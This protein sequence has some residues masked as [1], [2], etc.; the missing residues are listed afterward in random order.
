MKFNILYEHI[1]LEGL[2]LKIRH[3]H[4][5]ESVVY[6]MSGETMQCSISHNNI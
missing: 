3:A 2:I 6:K 4:K 1:L 5:K